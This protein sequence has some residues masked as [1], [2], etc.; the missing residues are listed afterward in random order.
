MN[1]ICTAIVNGITV[2]SKR[3]RGTFINDVNPNNYKAVW[4]MLL[5][6]F[7]HNILHGINSIM[8]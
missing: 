4:R 1:P 8:R 2:P 3:Y 5:K 7:T 6:M